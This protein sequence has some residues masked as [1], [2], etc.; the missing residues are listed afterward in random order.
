[1][2]NVI[3]K[4]LINV[5]SNDVR[6]YRDLKK[7]LQ[8]KF[9]AIKARDTEKIN[10]TTAAQEGVL[11]TIAINGNKRM[12]LVENIAKLLLADRS[13]K[14]EVTITEIA[15]KV[16]EP[17]KGKLIA[18][19]SLLH[20]EVDQVQSLSRI[21]NLAV[22]KMLNHLDFIFKAIVN[23][24]SNSGVYRKT[25]KHDNASGSGLIDAIA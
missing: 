23:V 9:E 17:E 16:D 18:L 7:I 6:A 24:D 12:Q 25:G 22:K 13:D 11:R 8:D 15:S 4:Q 19:K 3:I 20:K 1:M 2:N 10:E 5:L 21:N 14:S